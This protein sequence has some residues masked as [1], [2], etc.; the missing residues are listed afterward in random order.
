MS[1]PHVML[2]TPLPPAVLHTLEGQVEVLRGDEAADRTAFLQEKGHKCRAV[3]LKGHDDFGQAELQLLPNLEIVACSSAGVEA[4]DHDA[5]HR[6]GIPLTNASLALK[7]E[8]A[9]TALMLI[10]ATSKSLLPCDAY[11]RSGEWGKTGPYPLLSTLKGKR[12]GLLGFGAIGQ[13]IAA[14]LTAM[15]L[16]IGY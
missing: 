2:L 5:L 14:R 1:K 13:E 10:L 16:E 11:V 9:D 8:V 7:D 12:A 3:I 4:I 15:K 6:A